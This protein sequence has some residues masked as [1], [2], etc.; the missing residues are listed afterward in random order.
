MAF[1][2]VTRKSLPETLRFENAKRRGFET[3]WYFFGSPEKI[4]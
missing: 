4:F 2:R 3:T 1:P